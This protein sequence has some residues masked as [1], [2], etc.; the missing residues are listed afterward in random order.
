MMTVLG[1]ERPICDGRA[2]YALRSLATEFPRLGQ[3]T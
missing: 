3:P 2:M 1:H